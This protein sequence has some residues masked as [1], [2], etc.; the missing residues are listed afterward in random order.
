MPKITKEDNIEE[1]LKYIGLNLEKLPTFFKEYNTLEYRPLKAYEENTY[2]VYKY[3]PIS[4]IQILLTPT[5]RLNTLKEKYSKA[6]SI[7]SYLNPEKEEDIIKHT[8]FLKMLK[9]VQIEEIKEVEEE[10]KKLNKEVPFKVKFEENYWWQIYYSDISD[11]YFMLVPTED[12]EYATFFYLLKKQIEYHKTKKEEMIFVP[13]CYE[14]YASNYLKTSE[15]SDLEK[16]LWLFTKEW[17]NVY[18]VYDKKKNVNIEIV[19]ETIVY[20]GIESIYKNKLKTKEEATKFFKLVKALFILQTELPHHYNFTVK[21]NRYGALEFGY[22]GKKIDYDNMF[23]I[24]NDEYIKAKKQIINLQQEQVNLGTNLEK[25]KETSLKLDNEYLIKEKQI[26]TYLECKKTFLGKVRY[27]LKSKRNKKNLKGIIEDKKEEIKVNIEKNEI[28]QIQFITKDYYTIED[29]IK[30]YKDLDEI[31]GKVKNLKLDIDAINVKIQSMELKIKNANL[32]IEEIDKHE[33]NIFEFWKFTNKDE[34]LLL[35]SAPVEQKL[36]KKKIEKVYN[37]K[38]D[39]EEIGVLADKNQRKVFSKEDLDAIYLCTT[40]I[41]NVINNINEDN[42]LEESLV[43]LK[44]EA[45]N[46][47]ILFNTEKMD[48]FGNVSEDKTKITILGT[49]K[50]REAHKDKLKILDINKTTNMKEYKDKLLG[51]CNTINK[52]IE[53]I[54]DIPV[55]PI[56]IVLNKQEDLEGIKVFNINPEDAI[57]ELKDNKEIYL[58]KINLKQNTKII[59]FSNSVYYDNYNKTLPLG[60]DVTTKGIIDISKHEL[61]LINKNEFRINEEENEFKVNT[62]KI[63]TKEY[64]I[65]EED[66]F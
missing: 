65:I 11:T 29:I 25:L 22:D 39:L 3:I 52:C 13:I 41:I 23:N 33:K 56:Y 55:I 30:I 61:K 40:D 49:K 46:E 60:M 42:T 48:I 10:Q 1:K 27:F 47:R 9:S 17:P 20:D 19:G 36:V 45:K 57:K 12:L 44:E 16:Y 54:K 4:K 5:N 51:I 7:Y 53:N 18:E 62:K 15:I 43:N 28:P 34:T 32:Y 26:A 63:Y 37:F 31:L 21:I 50:H 8:T 6:S 58:Y 35:N 66:V 2:R 59:Y 64:E 38:E 24:L 14:N